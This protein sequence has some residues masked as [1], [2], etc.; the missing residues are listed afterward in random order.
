MSKN[1]D[2]ITAPESNGFLL[3]FRNKNW[4]H[5]DVPLEELKTALD[6]VNAWIEELM[7]QGKLAGGLPLL[8]G[9]KLVSGKGGRVVMDGPFP[10]SKEAIGGFIQLKV[11]SMEEAVA[12]AQSNPI[13]EYGLTVEVRETA[14]SCPASE[15]VR[16][17]L[18]SADLVSTPA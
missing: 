2:A 7:R 9:G 13:L 12:I 15:R 10:E 16:Q 4:D 18:A 3:L 5:A 1:A 11:S 6:R 8:D 14:A 17:R